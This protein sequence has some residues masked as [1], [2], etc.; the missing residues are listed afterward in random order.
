MQV[1]E[2]Q[3]LEHNGSVR[4]QVHVKSKRHDQP[5]WYEVDPEFE[6]FLSRRADGAI[7][8]L[9]IPAMAGGEDIEVDGEVTDDLLAAFNG[10][11]QSLVLKVMPSLKPIKVKGAATSERISDEG[12]GIASGFSAGVDSFCVLADHPP[13]S[14]SVA[15][16]THLL[17]NNVG[18][19]GEPSWGLFQ[20]RYER[21]QPAAAEFPLPL[22][23]V[24]SSVDMFYPN[25]AFHQTHT[26]RNA[27]VPLILQNG[28]RKWFYASGQTEADS[29]VGPT[30][31]IAFSDYFALPMISTNVTG[32]A[33]S[34]A[35]YT[36]VE[37][38]VKINEIP[39]SRRYLDVCVVTSPNCS[40][41]WKCLR[42]LMTLEIAGVLDEYSEV[43]DLMAYREVRQSFFQEVMKSEDLY[44]KEIADFAIES[45][46]SL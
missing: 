24:D 44:L 25:F 15:G 6:H 30:E 17:F 10:E 39:Q 45:G 40:K 18:S 3:I 37:K 11:Y 12:R 4:Y 38:T 8:A 2:T 16:I 13:H 27:S 1:S 36:R 34:G 5:L 26:P 28:I 20:K 46:F 43:F 35:Q 19:H 23:R 22:I 21:V 42:T 33:L 41:C 29:F 7:L 9:L 32:L 14:D 31:Y